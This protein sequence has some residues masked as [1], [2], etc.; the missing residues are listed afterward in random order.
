MFLL[1]LDA[2]GT[3]EPQDVNTKHFVYIG[4]CLHEG[5]WF[6]LDKRIQALKSRYCYSGTDPDRFELH[7]KQFA[8]TIKEQGEIADFENLSWTDRRARVLTVR[9]QKID[10]ETTPKDKRARRDRYKETDPFIH[11]SRRERSRLLEEAVD[12]IAGHERVRLFG[13]AVCK[14][15]PQV[16]GGQVDAVRQAFEQVVGRF[17]RFLQKI[18]QRKLQKSPRRSIDHGLLILD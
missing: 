8:V 13:E 17:D 18:D 12:I 4:L 3:A 7:V 6:G 9:Q 5:S 11:L 16:R 14:A 1:Y 15:H 2:S 10:A